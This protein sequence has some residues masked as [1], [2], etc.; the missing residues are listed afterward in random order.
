MIR[1]SRIAAAFAVL[2]LACIAGVRGQEVTTVDFRADVMSSIKIAD[3]TALCLVGHVVFFHN[4]AVITCDSAIRYSDRMMDCYRNVVVNK[5]STFIYGDKADYNGLLNEAR[6]Y[7]PLIKMVDKDATL[8]TYNFTF[9]T[10]TNIGRYYG[11]GTMSQ[12]DNLMESDEGY[13]YADNR[14]LIGVRNVEMQNPQYTISSD[15]VTYNMD[16]E[17]ATFDTPSYIWNDQDEFL[18]ARRGSYNAKED[19]YTFTDSSY[20]M[21]KTQELW[22]DTIVYRQTGQDAVLRNN[23]QIADQE[24][25]AMAFGDYGQYWG[26]KKQAL[27]TRYRFHALGQHLHL[28][29]EPVP[30]R[31]C[32]DAENGGFA[33]SGNSRTVSCRRQRGGPSR[34]ERAGTSAD[35]D[36]PG[37]ASSATCVCPR[38]APGSGRKRH[39]NPG[40]LRAT[41]HPG[42]NGRLPGAIGAPRTGLRIDERLRPK[43]E[44]TAGRP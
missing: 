30:Q 10:L 19:L 37:R 2:L 23:I 42:R 36:A 9:N 35:S 28:Y 17:I 5:D 25:K 44:R 13:Y 1:R 6:I 41:E 26:D 8:Y 12:K 34:D 3:S 21:T 11:G 20:I 4:G 16:T 18:T 15:S 24:Q 29:A 38:S 14:E 32:S 40:R 7:S 31:L 33:G 27:L 43:G 22:A 39:G